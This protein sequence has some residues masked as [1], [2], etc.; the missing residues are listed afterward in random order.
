[1]K[2]QKLKCILHTVVRS[3]VSLNLDKEN[4]K[5]GHVFQEP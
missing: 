1:M 5:S 2:L 3:K 4:I